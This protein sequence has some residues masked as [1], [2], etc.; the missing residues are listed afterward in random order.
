[1]EDKRNKK[2]ENPKPRITPVQVRKANEKNLVVSFY[3]KGHTME[4]AGRLAAEALGGR[5]PFTKTTVS[6][7]VNEAIEQWKA[8]KDELVQNHKAVELEKINRLEV[9]YWAAWERSCAVI[10]T[11]KK[12]KKK[13]G[14]GERLKL[15]QAS[16]DEE[17]GLGDPRYLQGIQWCIDKRCLIL[18]VDVPQTAIQINNNQPGSTT[19]IRRVVFRTRETTMQPQIIIQQNTD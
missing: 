5:I 15:V 4:E 18:G 9:T 1:M 11:H 7:Y 8:N 16:S 19:L 10:K 6:H 12:V 17:Q 2:D 14:Q 3:M 13:D